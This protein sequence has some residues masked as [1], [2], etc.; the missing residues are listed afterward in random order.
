M[1]RS[2]YY[3]TVFLLGLFKLV[4]EIMKKSSK[5]FFKFSGQA[6]EK[7]SIYIACILEI[8][9]NIFQETSMT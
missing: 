4:V 8:V 3:T 9:K 7:L 5:S 2:T 6:L 1:L